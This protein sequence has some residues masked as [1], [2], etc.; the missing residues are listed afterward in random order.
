MNNFLIDSYASL[1][2]YRLSRDSNK[3]PTELLYK[4]D[5]LINPTITALACKHIIINLPIAVPI[6]VLSEMNTITARFST[7]YGNNYI[8]YNIPIDREEVKGED[9]DLLILTKHSASNHKLI[10]DIDKS[11]YLLAT[12]TLVDGELTATGY[13][14]LSTK[15]EDID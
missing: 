2:E 11:K 5:T 9:Y 3:S 14:L 12:D 15:I 6:E 10:K 4:S 1:L 13:K 8:P 7:G